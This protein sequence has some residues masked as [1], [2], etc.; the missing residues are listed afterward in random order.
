[1]NEKGFGM[2]RSWPRRSVLAKRKLPIEGV[3]RVLRRFFIPKRD[4]MTGCYKQEVLGRTN[5]PT[6]PI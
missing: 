6:F 4:E 1:M 5:M 3:R 2:K